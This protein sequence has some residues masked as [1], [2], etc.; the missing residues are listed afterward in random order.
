[1]IEARDLAAAGPWVGREF[2]QFVR[3]VWPYAR[4]LRAASQDPWNSRRLPIESV[5]AP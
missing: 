4:R 1:M 5:G 2:C 3:N